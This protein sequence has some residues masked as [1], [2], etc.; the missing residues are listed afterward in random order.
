ML[1]RVAKR[2]T[3]RRLSISS[4]PRFALYWAL[5]S[6]PAHVPWGPTQLAEKA[7]GLHAKLGEGKPLTPPKDPAK[8][9]GMVRP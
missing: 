9:D 6:H 3:S 4:A 7:P 8:D 1:C 2:G 5:V